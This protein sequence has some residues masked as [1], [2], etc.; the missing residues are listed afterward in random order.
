M[1]LFNRKDNEDVGMDI[2]ENIKEPF[3]FA[4]FFEDHIVAR[5]HM[6]KK[7]LDEKGILFFL[8]SPF[9]YRS[10]LIT[11]M[12]IIVVCVLIGV[13][14]RG[15]NL[16][17]ETRERNAA[18]ELA[19]LIEAGTQIQAGKISVR[20]LA[21]S[22]YD[23]QHML[24]FLIG[25][26]TSEGV[27]SSTAR[28]IVE[29]EV[30]RGVVY[31]EDIWYTYEVFPIDNARRLLLVYVNN[32]EQN[33]ETGIFNIYIEAKS[34]VIQTRTPME[35]VL[36]N[37]Q[38]TNDLFNDKGV[39]I[40]TLTNPI[41]N[42]E[43][44]PIADAKEAL[45]ELLTNY[46]LEEERVN[47][48]PIDITVDITTA[49]LRKFAEANIELPDMTD[50]STTKDLIDMPELGEANTSL[51]ANISVTH[52]GQKYD[53]QTLEDIKKTV[54]AQMESKD[55]TIGDAVTPPEGQTES[56]AQ[57]PEA[58]V[59]DT[60]S[61]SDEE[62]VV[63]EQLISLDQKTRAVITGINNVN[64]ANR[65]KYTQLSTL[66]II[67]NQ[68]I[69]VNTFEGS[70]VVLTLGEAIRAIS[71][72]ELEEQARLDLEDI[73]K[74]SGLSSDTLLSTEEMA[75][76]QAPEPPAEVKGALSSDVW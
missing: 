53:K 4:N 21:S 75:E 73:Q 33:D 27:P 52:N 49:E 30:N 48:L 17:E 67:L 74:S 39:D 10:R 47:S 44:T 72:E 61:F 28:Y 15:G 32:Q 69:D 55:I 5:W 63:L 40:S 51:N 31:P 38:E 50:K 35:I 60:S 43:D 65:T 62:Q 66:K 8:I 56:P 70:G 22:Q 57:E 34:D 42:N 29:L 23:K 58:S 6:L 68:G 46:E 16:L 26:D 76:E 24:A 45:E 36:S 59:S 11:K 54:P 20:P 1:G 12:V 37:T 41:F 13:I 18:S 64:T 19:G 7:F 71:E 25:G 3:S 14:P 9:Q 2:I